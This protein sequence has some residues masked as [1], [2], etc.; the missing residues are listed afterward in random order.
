MHDVISPSVD[1]NP[2][3][4]RRHQPSQPAPARYL[5]STL[6]KSSNANPGPRPLDAANIEWSASRIRH[7]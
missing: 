2:G 6:D 5:C 1:V 3:T 4:G 7:R